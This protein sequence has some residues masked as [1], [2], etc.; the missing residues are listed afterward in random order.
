MAVPG[1]PAALW[2]LELVGFA[3][4][5]GLVGEPLRALA[6]R[7]V[8]AWRDP[9]PIERILLDLFLGGAAMYLLAAVRLGVFTAGAVLAVVV[10]GAI[11]SG[12]LAVAHRRSLRAFA[13]RTAA[14]LARPGPLLA[15]LTALG[16]F[17]FELSVALPMATGNTLD[18]GLFTTY[19]ALL[20]GH[21]SLPISFRP[22][23]DPM[24]LYPQGTTVW[25]AVAQTLFGLPPARTTLLVTPLFLGLAPLGG[26]VVGRRWLGTDA[27]GAA[28]ALTIGWLG[29]GTRG[30]VGGSNDFVLAFP[31][32]LLALGYAAD[33]TKADAP[34]WADAA[35]FGLLV[36]YS[37]A[38]NPVGAEWLLPMLFGV[39]LVA[40]A[41]RG[42]SVR[43]GVAR[44]LVALGVALVPVIP[45]LYV[46]GLGIHSPGYVPGAAPAVGVPPPGLTWSQWVG[47]VDPFLFRP[48]DVELSPV[49]VLRAELAALLLIGAAL[50]VL[51]PGRSATGRYLGRFR[52]LALGSFGV[53]AVELLL[54]VASRANVPGARAIGPLTSGAELSL[55]LFTL[56][57][58][59][60]AVP[61]ALLLERVGHAGRRS[62]A[63]AP[64]PA[65]RRR[66]ALD[67]A[68]GA[69]R[70]PLVALVAAGAIV[71]PG[72]VL[73]PT[74]LGPV[75]HGL[76]QDFGNVTAGDFALLACAGANLPS[77]S[78]VLV[79]PGSAAW[80]LPGYAAHVVLLY[81]FVPGWPTVNASYTRI[82]SELTNGTLDAAGRAALAALAVDFIAVTGASSVLW[83]PFSPAPLAGDPSAFSDVF[84]AEDAYLF[85]T[86]P[87]V[88]AFPCG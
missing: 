33:W 36:G 3:V 71:A 28:F 45:S 81:P 38:I 46:L 6:A 55:W 37:A 23:A 60:A 15:L 85:A 40:R 79:A 47:G 19:V 67:R 75:L 39:V 57:A 73:T 76:Y 50:L 58:F 22:F 84:H 17:V 82:V 72:V 41:S 51:V 83:P 25:F 64:V 18:S 61:L 56:Y 53:L 27:A 13:R 62:E 88:P 1:P 11:A 35:G 54:L 65:R 5:V 77:G 9:R 14:G 30:L 49:P 68:S 70:L 34:S 66:F 48:G 59:V 16:L 2:A 63:P 44:W 69:G 86:A 74:Q 20:R 10:A 26:F 43:P 80:F 31:L 42:L 24:I 32:V 4:A 29:P 52:A 12:A 21:G 8:T 87:G 7:W 78:R